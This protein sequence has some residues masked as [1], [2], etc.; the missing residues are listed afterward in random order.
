MDI[1]VFFTTIKKVFKRED[2]N[3]QGQA[4]MEAFNGHN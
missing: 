1:K 2:I 3:E 4:T